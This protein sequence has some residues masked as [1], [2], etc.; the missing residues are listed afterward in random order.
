[1]YHKELRVLLDDVQLS[2]YIHKKDATA[3]SRS[4][5]TVGR[6]ENSKETA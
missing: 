4:S 2:A 1:M 6:N 5:P 3:V